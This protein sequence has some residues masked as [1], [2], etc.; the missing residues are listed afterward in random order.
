MSFCLLKDK[1]KVCDADESLT[2]SGGI[3][4]NFNLEG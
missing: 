2:L 3:L 4:F 1:M